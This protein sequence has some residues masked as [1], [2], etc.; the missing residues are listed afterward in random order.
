MKKRNSVLVSKVFYAMLIPTILMNAV[1]CIT[2]ASDTIIVGNFVGENALAAITFSTPIFMLTNLLGALIA[3]GGTTAMGIANGRGDV[4]EANGIFSVMI[5]A[6]I[7]FGLIVA[8]AG[9]VLLDPI[10]KILGAQNAQAILTREYAAVVFLITPA[11]MLN[12]TLAFLIRSDGRPNLAMTGMLVSIAANILMDVLFIISF[13]MG[14]KGAALAT[15]LA[16]AISALILATHFFS[17]KNTLKLT[18]PPINKIPLICKSGA[19]TSLTFIYMFITI[20][21]FNNFIMN[22]A[23]GDGV[24]VYTVI[25]NVSAIAMSIFEGLSQTVQPMF[26]VYYGERNNAAI[27]ACFRLAVKM[28][29]ILGGAV[30]LLLEIFPH[31]LVYAFGVT[32][33]PAGASATGIRIFSICIILMTFN[34]IMGYYY[35]STERPGLAS[36][37][38]FIRNLAAQIAGAIVF[39]LIWGLNGIW[40]SYLFSEVTALL[41][42][43]LFAKRIGRKS[44]TRNE[45]L[46]EG[47]LLLPK[48]AMVYARE[49][50]CNLTELQTVL[51]EAEDFLTSNGAPAK[52][53]GR[54]RL[55]IEELG[56]N[57]INHGGTKLRYVEVR[58][59]I[60]DEIKVIIRDDGVLFD[61]S[62]FTYA[63]KPDVS[64]GQGLHLVRQTALSFEYRPVLGM[65]RT[66]LTY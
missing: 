25:M 56:T 11:F 27:K 24:I 13:D 16:Q 18:R 12:I 1:T 64:G 44:E 15:G 7:A 38:V 61:H 26:S 59:V 3:V 36:M 57:V 22:I 41:I 23:G 28:T 33:S 46:E 58:I 39:G 63:G 65:N 49:L 50:S 5:L 43:F 30:T 2:S 8:V 35:Q 29:L 9:T 10:V 4:R 48:Q 66:L 53:A 42:W 40:F 47:F 20:L 21:V 14:V 19:G 34:V 54:V 31:A 51:Q 60:E 55:A 45:P 32:G 6:A 62:A 17:K 37:I 52:R